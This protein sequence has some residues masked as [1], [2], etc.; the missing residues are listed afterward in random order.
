M[1]SHPQTWF[2]S[3]SPDNTVLRCA[4]CGRQVERGPPAA[5]HHPRRCPSCGVECALLSWKGRTIQVVPQNA[6][7]AFTAVLCWAQ[8]HLD[9]LEYVE[10]ICA[11]E[12]I[13][14][15]MSAVAVHS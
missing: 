11:L 4:V 14:D 3:T 9:E 6:P 7:P 1:S 13:A 2:S 12:E 5:D 15:S 10:F 8:H